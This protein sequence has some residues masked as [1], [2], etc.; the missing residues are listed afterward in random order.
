[1][2]REYTLKMSY[3]VQNGKAI[4]CTFAYIEHIR[5]ALES[6]QTPKRQKKTTYLRKKLAMADSNIS[7]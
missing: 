7:N 5:E 4:K 2:R 1:M 3:N 6:T